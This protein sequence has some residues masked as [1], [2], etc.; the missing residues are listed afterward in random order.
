MNEFP[1]RFVHTKCKAEYISKLQRCAGSLQ[2]LVLF[3]C[4]NFIIKYLFNQYRITESVQNRFNNNK[5]IYLKGVFEGKDKSERKKSLLGFEKKGAYLGSM[6][7]RER[8]S[9]DDKVILPL[10]SAP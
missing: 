8:L 3:F 2:H 4:A 10:S 7:L 9:V 5:K 6:T 1:G